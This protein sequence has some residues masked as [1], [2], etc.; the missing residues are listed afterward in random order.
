MQTNHSI[1][2]ALK[3][4][5]VTLRMSRAGLARL[6]KVSE[7]TIAGLEGGL[8]RWVSLTAVLPVL[9]LR[10]VGVDMIAT[11]RAKRS[12]SVP[13]AAEKSGLT[14]PTVRSIERDGTGR[15]E[16]LVALAGVLGVRLRLIEI[17]AK[18]FSAGGAALTSARD[19]W[20]TPPDLLAVILV[21]L[22][23]VEFDV[24]PCSPEGLAPVPAC[25]R[26]TQ[27]EDGLSV[28]WGNPGDIVYCNPPFSRVDA[29]MARC[30][31]EAGRGLRIV[32]LVPARTGPRWLR[33]HVVRGG[34]DLIFLA[35]RLRF[36]GPEGPGTEPA[37]FDVALA[38]WNIGPDAVARL[39][40][41]LPGAWHVPAAATLGQKAA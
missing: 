6:A 30:A 14:P 7:P 23:A 15:L 38:C 31:A 2:E 16:T 13:V 17:S 27:A 10:L 29:F 34:A 3:A 41:A 1:A 19:E 39:L 21:A 26:I 32:A 5:R 36:G 28:P 20:Y 40:T 35:Q 22:D 9:G 24:D 37:P 11:A 25:R 33:E 12:W 8:G 4:R 18:Y